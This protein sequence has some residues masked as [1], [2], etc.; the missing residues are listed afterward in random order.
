MV[1]SKEFRSAVAFFPTL[2][3]FPLLIIYAMNPIDVGHIFLWLVPTSYLL[4]ID[5]LIVKWGIFWRNH[6][7][8]L[9]GILIWVLF[10][11]LAGYVV[12]PDGEWLSHFLLTPFRVISFLLAFTFVWLLVQPF[13]IVIIS[14][15][16]E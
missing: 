1:I 13:A 6:L 2:I 4:C 14:F 11:L 12:T 3:T 7:G 8:T 16:E 9:I 10:S 5:R 15:R